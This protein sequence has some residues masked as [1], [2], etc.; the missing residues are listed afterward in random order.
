MGL[1]TTHDA[2]HGGYIGFGIWRDALAIAAGWP[3]VDRSEF[4]TGQTAFIDWGK[5]PVSDDDA[6]WGNWDKLP[7][8]PLLI[9][10]AHQ[11]C[12]G[13][14]PWE[15]TQALADR[16]WGLLTLIPEDAKDAIGW[17]YT[18]RGRTL[19]FIEGL[20]LAHSL[21]EDVEFY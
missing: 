21:K 18:L 5:L 17:Q 20:R 16:L 2:W 15:Y 8:D 13:R 11:D 7:E 14:I 12:E 9:L 6:L 3:M 19:T 4:N 10:L 1:D